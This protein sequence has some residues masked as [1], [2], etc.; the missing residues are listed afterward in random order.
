MPCP[1]EPKRLNK[2]VGQF[3]EGPA[4]HQGV[5]HLIGEDAGQVDPIGCR[6]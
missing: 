5:D 1:K 6:G 2:Q 3:V 4:R